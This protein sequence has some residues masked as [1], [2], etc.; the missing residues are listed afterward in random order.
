MVILSAVVAAVGLLRDNMPILVGAMVIAPLLGPHIALAFATT[1]ADAQMAR[2]AVKAGAFGF[3]IAIC[4][5]VAVGLLFTV[6]PSA[7]E[8]A[9]RTRVHPSDIILA[10]AAGIAG[11]L[12]FTT[13]AP[14]SLIGVMVAVALM[15]PIVTAGLLLGAAHFQPALGSLLLLLTNVICVNL[16]GV[17]TFLALGIRPRTWWE[18]TQAK[19]YT[20]KAIVIWSALLAVL[21][22][23]IY[24]SRGGA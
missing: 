17:V 13:G 9:S 10:L 6:E 23:A 2:A 7:R 22:V 15:P 14:S 18:A 1:L 3:L 16:A 24:L 8:I 12:S 20:Q 11:S 4:F 21:A 19:R 5:A